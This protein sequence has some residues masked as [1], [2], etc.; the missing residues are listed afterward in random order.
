LAENVLINLKGPF[1]FSLSTSSSLL[2]GPLRKK[3]ISNASLPH[4]M[5]GKDDQKKATEMSKQYSCH[6][7]GLL[8]G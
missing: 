8:I 5:D 3:R 7:T 1:F 2:E 6:M 4:T